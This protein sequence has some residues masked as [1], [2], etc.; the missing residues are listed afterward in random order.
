MKENKRIQNPLGIDWKLLRKLHVKRHPNAPFVANSKPLGWDEESSEFVEENPRVLPVARA[1]NNQNEQESDMQPAEMVQTD[2]AKQVVNVAHDDSQHITENSEQASEL[3]NL[4]EDF[5]KIDA[6][7]VAFVENKNLCS[8]DKRGCKKYLGETFIVAETHNLEALH[9]VSQLIADNKN[10]A[11]ETGSYQKLAALLQHLSDHHQS[12][13]DYLVTL[14]KNEN[15]EVCRVAKSELTK[16]IALG[17]AYAKEAVKLHLPDMSQEIVSQD[18][19][20][21]CNAGQA[22]KDLQTKINS[23]YK[24]KLMP[25]VLKHIKLLL[26]ALNLDK[27]IDNNVYQTLV[28]RVLLLPISCLLSKNKSW[29]PYLAVLN[30][31]YPN[32]AVFLQDNY[33]RVSVGS[34]M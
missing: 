16:F 34:I 32:A 31:Q 4:E 9:C 11:R 12:Y 19:S 22:L 24:G 20:E 25:E 1:N 29:H 13:I 28:A 2:E 7:P 21:F 17:D 23:D 3:D 14:V 10:L 27:G 33:Q 6:L 18:N 30:N 26:A 15:D 5:E 8:K